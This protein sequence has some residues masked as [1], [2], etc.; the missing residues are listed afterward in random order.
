MK[1]PLPKKMN[2]DNVISCYKRYA[3]FYDKIFG[4]ILQPGRIA[5][6]NEINEILPE[7]ILEIGVGTGLMLPMYPANIPITA[8]DISTEMLARAKKKIC[9]KRQSNI[10]LLKVNG[11]RLPFDDSSFSCIVLPYTYSATPNPEKMAQEARRVCKKNGTIIIV[12]HFSD[13]KSFWK[14]LEKIATPF[15]KKIGFYSDFSYKDHINSIDWEIYK[16]YPVN[17]LN[18]SRLVVINNTKVTS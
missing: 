12:N 7:N 4:H 10:N 9:S 6:I 1:T 5:I 11:E 16:S 8:I 18:L 15:A 13:F 3:P 17:L 14:I 2:E